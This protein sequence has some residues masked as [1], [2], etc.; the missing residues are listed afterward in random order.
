MAHDLTWTAAG[1]GLARNDL[2]KQSLATA[3]YERPSN[4]VSNKGH[5]QQWTPA[6]ID[7]RQFPGQAH[8]SAGSA[9]RDLASGRRSQ[10]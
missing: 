3:A 5:A 1:G 6:D 10:G 9:Y 7:G 4:Q 8:R 2:L